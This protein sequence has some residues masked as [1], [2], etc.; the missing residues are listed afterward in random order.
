MKIVDNRINNANNNIFVGS[1]V[2]Y[3]GQICIV[4]K[5]KYNTNCVCLVSLETGEMIYRD[6]ITLTSLDELK[7]MIDI[8]RY[9]NITLTME[10]KEED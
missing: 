10:N 4:T 5:C 8:T 7:G 3:E 6:A 9:S 1:I 2:S